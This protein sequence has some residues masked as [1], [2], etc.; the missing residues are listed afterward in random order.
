MRPSIRYRRRFRG[1]SQFLL[2]LLFVVVVIVCVVGVCSC[3]LIVALVCCACGLSCALRADA[4][5]QEAN[6]LYFE[7]ARRSSVPIPHLSYLAT[8]KS[9]AV[10]SDAYPVANQN[11]S[12]TFQVRCFARCTATTHRARD[13]QDLTL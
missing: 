8:H 11:F 4:W 10:K 3:L 9:F 13:H 12:V 2:L 6:S 7:L 5:L 1:V